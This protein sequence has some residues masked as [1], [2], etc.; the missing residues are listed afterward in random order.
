MSSENIV[1]DA[2]KDAKQIFIL[3]ALNHIKLGNLFELCKSIPSD[4]FIGFFDR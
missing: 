2:I 4:G 3:H 1:K